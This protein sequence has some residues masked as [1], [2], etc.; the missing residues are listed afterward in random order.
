MT[1]PRMSSISELVWLLPDSAVVKSGDALG[2][3]SLPA[4]CCCCCAGLLS[5]TVSDGAGPKPAGER[6]AGDTLLCTAPADPG[7]LS[8]SLPDTCTVESRFFIGSVEIAA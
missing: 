6:L 1:S 8:P 2:C 3:S 4:P 7:A 5:L